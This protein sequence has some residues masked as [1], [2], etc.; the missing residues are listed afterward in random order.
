[1]FLIYKIYRSMNIKYIMFIAIPW[2]M[3]NAIDKKNLIE[4]IIKYRYYYILDL[5][6]VNNIEYFKKLWQSCSFIPISRKQKKKKRNIYIY[7]YNV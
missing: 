2:N 6:L 3:L 1:M 7:V 4:Q 5:P